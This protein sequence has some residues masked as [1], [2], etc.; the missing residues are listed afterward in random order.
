MFSSWKEL[1][2]QCVKNTT[3]T[4]RVGKK[5]VLVNVVYR[6]SHLL[7]VD[8]YL[9]YLLISLSKL[10]RA[11]VDFTNIYLNSLIYHM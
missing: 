5:V 7:F 6:E 1:T 8:H 2:K 10:D 4:S 11:Y 9:E 3:Q